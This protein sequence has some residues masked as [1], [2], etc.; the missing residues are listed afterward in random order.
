MQWWESPVQ[1]NKRQSAIFVGAYVFFTLLLRWY[2]I[3]PLL[4][5]NFWLS[6]AIGA[7]FLAVIWVLIKVKFLNFRE[8]SEEE[9]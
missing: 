1:L 5:G 2:Y 7:A 3:E 8:Q 9:Q 4:K 6:V